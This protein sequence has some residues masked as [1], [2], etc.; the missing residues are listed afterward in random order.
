TRAIGGAGP[1]ED[2]A[3][4]VLAGPLERPREPRASFEGDR[5]PGLGLVERGLK[6]L[7]GGDADRAPGRHR[8]GGVEESPWPLRGAGRD[9]RGLGRTQ[10]ENED[11][12]HAGPCTAGS[13]HHCVATSRP[14]GDDVRL[15]LRVRSTTTWSGPASASACAA[16][17]PALPITSTSQPASSD[18]T[19][20]H[21]T[22][23]M[24]GISSSM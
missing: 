22:A 18:G 10:T 24:W 2:P 20:S 16:S 1:D 14:T 13:K 9:G 19:S 3:C 15:V 17:S 23:A 12:Q 7:A 5:V 11:Q 6:V 21:M 8:G 4:P